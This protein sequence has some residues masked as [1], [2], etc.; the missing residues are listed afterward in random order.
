MVHA[1]TNDENLLTRDSDKFFF[2]TYL[3]FKNLGKKESS[4]QDRDLT[5]QIA[6]HTTRM[7]RLEEESEDPCIMGT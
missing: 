5:Y 3:K 2:P 1:L 4:S 7:D 6:G